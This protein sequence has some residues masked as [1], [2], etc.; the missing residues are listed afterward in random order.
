MTVGQI[1]V[2]CGSCLVDMWKLSG[3]GCCSAWRIWKHS[4]TQKEKGGSS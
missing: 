1:M 2:I 3:C 4:S